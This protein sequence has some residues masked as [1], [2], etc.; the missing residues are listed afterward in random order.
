MVIGQPAR[1]TICTTNLRVVL[2]VDLSEHVAAEVANFDVIKEA[3]CKDSGCESYIL[4]GC[5]ASSRQA[6]SSSRKH[7][8]AAPK[9]EDGK[10]DYFYLWRRVSSGQ[11]MRCADDAPV[12]R[13]IVR[14]FKNTVI[15]YE[16]SLQLLSALIRAT[17]SPRALN[18][19][20][21]SSVSSPSPKWL[22]CQLLHHLSWQR[23]FHPTS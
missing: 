6:F 4:C 23:A 19:L 7:F 18:K 2:G 20:S 1:Q 21:P 15:R 11:T 16:F 22:N 5:S 14:F 10:V 17:R 3:A 13:F 8:Q 12:W 9:E